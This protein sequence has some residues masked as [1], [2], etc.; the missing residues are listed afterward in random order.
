MLNEWMNERWIQEMGETT[1]CSENA[2]RKWRKKVARIQ[3]C[4]KVVCTC[5]KETEIHQTLRETGLASG[6]SS[7]K[8]PLPPWAGALPP[9]WRG[10]HSRRRERSE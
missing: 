5:P 2:S 7:R 6:G 1:L 9:E 3:Q 8:V 10:R 4:C